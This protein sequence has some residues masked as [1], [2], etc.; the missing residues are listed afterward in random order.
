MFISSE[1]KKITISNIQK[2]AV[3]LCW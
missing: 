1:Y 2:K 3:E